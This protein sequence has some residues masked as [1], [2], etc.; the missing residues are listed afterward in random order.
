MSNK[1][2]RYEPD[3]RI[4]RQLV[5]N[6]PTALAALLSQCG[7]KVTDFFTHPGDDPTGRIFHP[8]KARE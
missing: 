7:W 8:E 2:K 6:S 4:V 3:I 1:P 5:F